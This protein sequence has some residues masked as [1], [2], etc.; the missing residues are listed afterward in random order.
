MKDLYWRFD[1]HWNTWGNEAAAV[2]SAEYLVRRGLTGDV[3]GDRAANIED[4]I[5]NLGQ[6]LKNAR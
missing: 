6:T 5:T 2:L 4:L 1:G 3:S